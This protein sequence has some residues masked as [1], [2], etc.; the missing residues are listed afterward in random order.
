ADG[1]VGLKMNVPSHNL[2]RVL[3]SLPA[4]QK[5][6]IAKLSDTSWSAL[7]II[8][9]EKIVRELIPELKRLGATGIVEY[10]L[11]KVLY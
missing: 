8:V 10:P 6:T 5:P 11:N 4:L 9:G 3:M 7:E 1:L 2:D